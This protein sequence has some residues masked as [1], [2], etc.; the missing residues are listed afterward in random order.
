MPSISRLF[1]VAALG[2]IAACG[3]DDSS[4]NNNNN[5]N[6]DGTGKVGAA[7]GTVT[8]TDGALS[9]VVPA[10]ALSADTAITIEPL[11]TAPAEVG[12]LVMQVGYR[13]GPD[14]L[15]FATPVQIELELDDAISSDTKPVPFALLVSGGSVE[16]LTDYE[17]TF[18]RDSGKVRLAGKTSHFSDLVVGSIIAGDTITP[19]LFSITVTQPPPASLEVGET[20]KVGMTLKANGGALAWDDALAADYH[21][22]STSPLVYNGGQPTALGTFTLDSSTITAQTGT[23]GCTAEGAGKYDAIV[24]F[25][26]PSISGDA[27]PFEAIFM[28]VHV[29]VGL[30]LRIEQSVQCTA[31][32]TPPG[33]VAPTGIFTPPASAFFGDSSLTSL[34]QMFLPPP[35]WAGTPDTALPV[36]LTGAQGTQVVD[37]LTGDSLSRDVQFMNARGVVAMRG[38]NA[39][40][41]QLDHLFIFSSVTNGTTSYEP[42]WNDFGMLALGSGGLVDATPIGGTGNAPGIV[43]ALGNMLVRQ[44]ASSSNGYLQNA[45]TLMGVPNTYDPVINTMYQHT[46][47]GPILFVVDGAP[48]ELWIRDLVAENDSVKLAD[49]GDS[50]M[51]MR[52]L[53]PICA[54]S[55]SGSDTLGIFVWDGTSMPSSITPVTADVGVQPIGID[56]AQLATPGGAPRFAILTSN[57]GS[58]EYSITVVDDAGSIVENNTHAVDPAC[59][60]PGAGSWFFDADPEAVIKAIIT[61]NGSNN[62][63]VF[64]GSFTESVVRM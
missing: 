44:I 59:Q 30:A 39:Q 13:F 5:N 46:E 17:V 56:I 3:G 40:G 21:D 38:T 42:S 52:C 10:G 19:E 58:D 18:D 37:L 54:V 15:T 55:N 45:P 12:D 36:V 53:P 63:W 48:S 8:S 51:R 27:M 6:N 29:G 49:L 4:N 24:A 64:E 22:G 32:S 14:G 2:F 57:F 23:Y 62:Y 61:C 33:P 16:G 20:F 9:L 31:P 35:G 1:V 25:I 47:T 43:T 50:T 11:S 26:P 60:S 28:A 34:D 41:P 7:G